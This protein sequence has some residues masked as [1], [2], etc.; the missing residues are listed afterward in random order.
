MK[1]NTYSHYI[2]GKKVATFKDKS[3]MTLRQ[4]IEARRTRAKTERLINALRA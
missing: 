4:K 3:G 2:D 1:T